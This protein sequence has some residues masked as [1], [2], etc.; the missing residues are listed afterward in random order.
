MCVPRS[1][2]SPSK[3]FALPS[4]TRRPST[5]PTTPF[6][7][8]DWNS[9]GPG[10]L[11]AFCR[12]AET[13]AAARGCS[14][15]RSRLAASRRTSDSW[16]PAATTSDIRRGL[17]CVS[18]PVLSTTRVSTFSRTSRAS[19]FLIRTPAIAPRPTPTMMAMGVARP[20]AHGH[21]L[22]RAHPEPVADL[23]LVQRHVGLRAVLAEDSGR[24]RCEPE[25][26]PDR[27]TGPASSTELEHLPEQDEG[28]DDRRGLEVDRHLP[29]MRPEGRWEALGE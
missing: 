27:A 6:P 23:D 10:R 2:A 22:T 7:V 9:V 8:R 25:E 15:A 21:A 16:C 28:R 18:V 19:A 24:L 17:P 5:T 1:M 14:L 4:A 26:S 11:R 3:S 29:A 13:I 20:S 12:A